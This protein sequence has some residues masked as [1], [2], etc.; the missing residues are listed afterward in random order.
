VLS[1]LFGADVPTLEDTFDGLATF[2]EE[3]IGRRA[4][5]ELLR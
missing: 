2:V 3:H 1:A 5:L 4:L